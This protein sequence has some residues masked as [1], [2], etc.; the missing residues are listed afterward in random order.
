MTRGSREQERHKHQGQITYVMI[1]QNAHSLKAHLTHVYGRGAL[2]RE[3]HKYQGQ[4]HKGHC[5]HHMARA[6]EV[7]SLRPF[8]LYNDNII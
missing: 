4:M 2:E 7:A 8:H 5:V 1:I 3:R 6:R